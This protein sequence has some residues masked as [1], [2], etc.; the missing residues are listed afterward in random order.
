[1][2]SPK[3]PPKTLSASQKAAVSKAANSK[4]QEFVK[5]HNEKLRG[6]DKEWRRQ[7]DELNLE[8]SRIRREIQGKWSQK[9]REISAQKLS[10][11]EKKAISTENNAEKDALFAKQVQS[12]NELKDKI[13]ATRE[14]NRALQLTALSK[15]LEQLKTETESKLAAVAPIA[16]KPVTTAGGPASDGPAEEQPESGPEE[17]PGPLVEDGTTERTDDGLVHDAGTVLTMRGLGT[18]ETTIFEPLVH[19]V[20]EDLTMRGLGDAAVTVFEPVEITVTT[21][22]TMRG[23]DP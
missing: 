14:Q 11:K 3:V 10:V 4:R 12:Y 19:T 5:G 20:S 2:G 21:P 7:R 15:M 6:I 18:A 17:V 1:M 22:L 8:N 16:A 9:L 13:D 23:V